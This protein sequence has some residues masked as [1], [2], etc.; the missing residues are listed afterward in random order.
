MKKYV[1]LLASLLIQTCLGGIYAW[2]TFVPPLIEDYGLTPTQTQLVFGVTIAIFTVAMIFAGRLQNRYGPRIV[3]VLGGLFFGAGYVL[4]SFSN[5]SFIQIFAGIGLLTG[6]GIGFGYVCP[7]ATCVKW[8]P[9]N[10][11]LITGVSVAAF[12]AGAILLTWLAESALARGVNVLMIFRGIAMLYTVLILAGAVFLSVPQGSLDGEVKQAYTAA[13]KSRPFWLLFI[14]M[15]CGTFA[16]LLVIGN[17]K[18]I[19][20]DIGIE[21]LYAAMAIS[22]FS[23]GNGCG[24]IAWGCLIDKAGSRVIPLSLL[25]LALAVL[26]LL[27]ITGIDKGFVM[28]AFLIGFSFGACFVLYAASVGSLYGPQALG[29]VYPWIFLA[30]GISGIFGP[31]AGGLLYQTTGSY[32]PS[33]VTAAAVSGAGAVVLFLSAHSIAPARVKIPAEPKP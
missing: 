26:A 22:A 13:H 15:F 20:L 18:P 16:G 30:Y 28:I 10:K 1:I 29:S 19:G 23:V 9:E 33:I 17:L 2:S 3:A 8:F 5:G 27:V 6:I 25:T 4:A 31:T 14:G 11:G 12:G 24:R 32:L 7:L 21:P